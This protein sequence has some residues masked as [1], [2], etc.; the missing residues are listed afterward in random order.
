VRLRGRRRLDKEI[1]DG[2]ERG[3]PPGKKSEPLLPPEI[4]PMLRNR[5]H[6][7]GELA[8]AAGMA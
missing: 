2:A 1:P 7:V 8:K 3:T 4:Q 5:W 6:R